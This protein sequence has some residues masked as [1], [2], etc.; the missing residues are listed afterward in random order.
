M[1]DADVP[2]WDKGDNTD[3][4]AKGGVNSFSLFDYDEKESKNEEIEKV[5]ELVLG[6]K[7]TSREIAYYRYSTVKK[8]DVV[9]KL[10]KSDEH[11][12][13]IEKGHKYPDIENQEKLAQSN[14]LKLRHSIEDQNGEMEEMRSMLEQ[15]NREIAVLREEKRIP[16]VTQSFLEGKGTVYYTNTKDSTERKE[17]VN[18]T[19]LDKIADFIKKLS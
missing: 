3:N 2:L 8:G 19:W 17:L 16:F 14:I 13:I 11:K 9:N 5:Y 10:L 1:Q 18:N 4:Y 6:R 7:P 12:R 15:K